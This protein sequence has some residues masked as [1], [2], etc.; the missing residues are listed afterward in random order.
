MMQELGGFW[1]DTLGLIKEKKY[2]EAEPRL[3]TMLGRMPRN[4]E[5]LFLLGTTKISLGKHGVGIALLERA[6][7]L[8]HVSSL[9]HINLGNAY[10]AENDYAMG[11]LHYGIAQQ[12]PGNPPEIFANIATLHIGAGS[13]EKAV[14]LCDKTLELA[15]DS[16]LAKFNRALARLELGDWGAF[17][18]YHSASLAHGDRHAREYAL[19]E[20]ACP[21]WDG[22]PGK[23]VVL[24]G[25][26]GIGD[27]IMFASCIPDA[28][29]DNSVIVECDSR[30]EP[31]FRRSFPGAQ[32]YGTLD[33]D[34]IPW[35]W[36]HSIDASLPIAGLA[37][38]YRSKG[39]FPRTQFLKADDWQVQEW[40]KRL[41]R[42]TVA[43]SWLGGLKKTRVEERSVPLELWK[44]ILDLRHEGVNFIS[45][46]WHPESA[47]EAKAH[48]VEANE[49]VMQNVDFTA[50]L[51]KAC[52][53]VISVTNTNAHL[54]GAL[55]VE[56]WCLTPKHAPWAF[57]GEENAWYRSVKHY[58]QDTAGEWES[59]IDRVADDLR[60]R[61]KMKAAAE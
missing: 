21:E 42:P 2:K 20:R 46:Q 19:P 12:L 49:T 24:H 5:L 45:V 7:E 16:H 61:F 13:P 30:L 18:D 50:S 26:Q 32:I 17:T 37:Q 38:F 15:P 40:R 28:M 60:A 6:A 47:D 8:G 52:D 48:G 11:A 43:I 9:L 14:E 39:E 54:A 56:C 31:L 51:M 29:K 36:W 4:P 41:K 10:V 33:R 59:V 25:E 22:K 35:P 3:E 53:L 34:E 44:P 27:E 55:G 57:C 58:R 1:D 23:T